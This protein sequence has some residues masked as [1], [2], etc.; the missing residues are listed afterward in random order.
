[1]GGKCSKRNIIS[2]NNLL[3]PKFHYDNSLFAYHFKDYLHISHPEYEIP[4]QLEL[5][6]TNKLIHN[7]IHPDSNSK[8]IIEVLYSTDNECYSMMFKIHRIQLR[9]TDSVEIIDKDLQVPRCTPLTYTHIHDQ[10]HLLRNI[11]LFQEFDSN[12]NNIFT[13][14]V[15]DLDQAELSSEVFNYHPHFKISVCKSSIVELQQQ[16]KKTPEAHWQ[17]T[18]TS[19][20]FYHDSAYVPKVFFYRSLTGEMN[21]VS[22]DPVHIERLPDLNKPPR[23]Q[24]MTVRFHQDYTPGLFYVTKV[25]NIIFKFVANNL[26]T[27]YIELIPSNRMYPIRVSRNAQTEEAFNSILAS[28][29]NWERRNQQ[30]CK[31]RQQEYNPSCSAMYA[32]E[33]D[34]VFVWMYKQLFIIHNPRGNNNNISDDD[35]PNQRRKKTHDVFDSIT[36]SSERDYVQSS[37]L[38]A[39]SNMSMT[40]IPFIDICTPEGQSPYVWMQY[41]KLLPDCVFS[42]SKFVEQ[43]LLTWECKLQPKSIPSDSL[44]ARQHLLAWKPELPTTTIIYICSFLFN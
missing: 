37:A 16:Y 7:S 21:V 43:Q 11:A 14:I 42:H 9:H 25:S 15:V 33:S 27:P 10:I 28:F 24:Q 22:I 8:Y 36:F 3:T 13:L 26:D 39:M 23:K 17:L 6:S 20:L 44:F 35:D 4:N 38:S 5:Q 12:N 18:N 31:S 19:R 40:Y 2:P 1:M 41:H 34:Q 30:Q 32:Q 29:H